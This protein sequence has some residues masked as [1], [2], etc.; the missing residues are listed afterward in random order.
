MYKGTTPTYTFV[1]PEGVNLENA[2]KIWV[3]FSTMDERE[4]FS[5]E[6]GEITL[7]DSQT[8]EVY[9]TQEDTL[10]L[11]AGSVKVQINWIYTE[12]TKVKR[13]CSEKMILN[14]RSNLKEVV[15]N[16]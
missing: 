7:T 1:A 9:L 15:L 2:T 5:K 16:E 4:I 12:G 3:T 10:S 13:A 8:I 6:S 14:A 11:P